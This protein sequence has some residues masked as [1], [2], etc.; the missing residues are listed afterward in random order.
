MCKIKQ[1]CTL[2]A[3]AALVI[4]NIGH[5][6][7]L[8]TW[9]AVVGASV[10][11]RKQAAWEA[12]RAASRWSGDMSCMGKRQKGWLWSVAWQLWGKWKH[13]RDRRMGELVEME[14]T[15]GRAVRMQ[16]SLT[17]GRGSWTSLGVREGLGAGEKETGLKWWPAKGWKLDNKW[18]YILGSNRPN[19]KWA[20]NIK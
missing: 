18:A 5:S 16:E 4:K 3:T 13:D 11:S 17:W 8:G 20:K 1:F 14:G 12:W 19:P 6:G 10:A 9:S 7:V 15:T 2:V